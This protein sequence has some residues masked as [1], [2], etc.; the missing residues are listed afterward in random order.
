MRV[1]LPNRFTPARP[2]RG[3]TSTEIPHFSFRGRTNPE[4]GTSGAKHVSSTPF[5]ATPPLLPISIRRST[6]CSLALIGTTTRCC[7]ARTH[8]LVVIFVRGAIGRCRG[9]N[10]GTRCVS[11]FRFQHFLAKAF[12]SRPR[13]S[14]IKGVLGTRLKELWFLSQ[15]S[16]VVTRATGVVIPVAICRFSGESRTL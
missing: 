10:L 3:S 8:S 9:V 15:G 4:S 16:Q 11:R 12:S 7:R 13:S 5:S 14:I 1:F 6:C 2:A